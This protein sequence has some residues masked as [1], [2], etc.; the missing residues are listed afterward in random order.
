MSK[1]L[2]VPD[3]HQL[4]VAIQTLRLS[5]VMAAVLGGPTKDEARAIIKRLCGKDA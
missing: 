1:Q 3:Q 4:A 5:D 2:S